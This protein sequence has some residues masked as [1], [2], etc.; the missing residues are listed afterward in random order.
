MSN[1]PVIRLTVGVEHEASLG[2]FKDGIKAIIAEI[3]KDPPK[4]K[5]GLEINQDKLNALR[6][7]ISAI[8][9]TLGASGIN[10]GSVNAS[11]LNGVADKISEIS[12]KSN[13]AVSGIMNIASSANN[14]RQ[15]MM[16]MTAGLDT[17]S[18]NIQ[19]LK[20]ALSS[21]N[22]LDETGVAKIAE[23]LSQAEVNIK[24]ISSSW[25]ETVSQVENGVERQQQL[26][27]LK[28]E[29]ANA[30][31]KSLSYLM[32]YNTETGEIETTIGRITQNFTNTSAS[33]KQI[34]DV[35]V[36]A[37]DLMSKNANAAGLGS[38]QNLREQALEIQ[39]VFISANLNGTSILDEYTKKGV[40]TTSVVDNIRT[41]MS[42]LNREM[43]QV[44][45]SG[46]VTENQLNDVLI[47]ANALIKNNRNA[48]SLDI[49]KALAN[50][51]GTLKNAFDIASRT[52]MTVFDVLNQGDGAGA[53]FSRMTSSV[54]ILNR[55]LQFTG[56]TGNVTSE[57][58]AK[59]VMNVR[60][61]LN[62]N[63]NASGLE[64]YKK[65]EEL[66]SPIS[67]LFSITSNNAQSAMDAIDKFGMN[68][69]TIMQDV[70]KAIVQLNLDIQATGTSGSDLAGKLAGE[71][72]NV[73]TAINNNPDASG[74]AS[75]KNA[76]LVVSQFSDIL[77]SANKNG[78]AVA[79][80]LS[81]YGY[82]PVN[83]INTLKESVRLLNDEIK[84]TGTSGNSGVKN[85]ID[86]VANA[87]KLLNSNNN[88]S[89]LNSY[90]EVE[91][92]IRIISDALK[93][94]ETNGTTFNQALASK[95]ISTASAMK[96]LGDA[97][98]QL[99]LDIENTGLSGS[100]IAEKLRGEIANAQ[101]VIDKNPDAK[102]LSSY[103]NVTGYIKQL[104][105]AL[106]QAEK[107]GV[108]A[109]DAL[110]R[111]GYT[112]AT[113]VQVLKDSVK[114]LNAEINLTGTSGSSGIQKTIDEVTRATKVL[115]DNTNA[116]G[117]DSYARVREQVDF[118]NS[119]INEARENGITLEGVLSK[120][121]TTPAQAMKN[122]RESVSQLNLEL[123]QTGTKGSTGI[124][125]INKLITQINNA[126]RNG[127][128]KGFEGTDDY[129]RLVRFRDMLKS[130]SDTMSSG[131]GI[132]ANVAAQANNIQNFAQFFRQAADALTSFNASLSGSE[133]T[134][135]IAKNSGEYYNKLQQIN[136]IIEEID[137]NTTRWN[138]A[139]KGRSANS[140]RLYTS[141]REEL[142]NLSRD[143]EN[144]KITS[145][146]FAVRIGEINSRMSE[147]A[148]TIRMAGENTQT[149]SSVLSKVSGRLGMWFSATTIIMRIVS[150]V[151]KMITETVELESAMTQLRIVTDATNSKMEQFADTSYRIAS[152]LGKNVKEILGSIE[153]FSRLGYSLEDA[154]VLTEYATILSNVAAV[155]ADDATS[156]LTSIIKGYNFDVQNAQHVADVLIEVGQKYA[157][158]AGEL[159]EAFK[160]SGAALSATNTSFEKSAALI[161]A[162]NASV[163]DSSTVGT[164]LKTISARIRGS[165]SDL[166]ELGESTDDLAQGFSKYADEIKSLTGFDIMVNK[167]SN[168]FKDLYDIMEGIAGT[169]DNLSDTQQ[170]RVAEILGGTRQLQV[171]SSI[172]T[173]WGDAADAYKS[174]ISSAGVATRVNDRYMATTA[175]HVEQL[176]VAFSE[177][178]VATFDTDFLKGIVDTGTS[179]LKIIKF[180]VEN[181]KPIPTLLM[182]IAAVKSFKSTDNIFNIVG[183]DA[184]TRQFSIF[185]QE[186]GKF[187]KSLSDNG[188]KGTFE[189]LFKKN[190]S[191]IEALAKY[192][193]LVK[194]GV[195]STDALTQA[196]KG[197]DAASKKVIENY[198][199]GVIPTFQ[200][201]QKQLQGV[202]LG[203]KAAAVA[204]NIL[205]AALVSIG[206][207]LIMTAINTVIQ[208]VKNIVTS[209]DDS[210]EDLKNYADTIK[211]IDNN[212]SSMNSEL[213][214]NL[215][216]LYELEKIE[217]PT[218]Y[219]Q[220]QIDMLKEA[221]KELRDRIRLLKYEL[222]LEVDA[223]D[224]QANQTWSGFKSPQKLNFP[225]W[226][227]WLPD[228]SKAS[229]Q[230]S[231]IGQIIAGVQGIS[232]FAQGQTFFQMAY[233]IDK[234]KSSID[235]LYSYKNVGG[236]FDQPDV[237][238]KNVKRLEDKISESQT[239]I[240]EY[241][242][243][244]ENIILQ[245]NPDIP[246]NADI[247]AEIESYISLI[248]NLYGQYNDTGYGTFTSVY[249]SPEFANVR[250]RLEELAA[251]GE[252]TEETFGSVEGIDAFVEA[253]R[254][255]NPELA[256]TLKIIE[257]VIGIVNNKDGVSP[258][259]QNVTASEIKKKIDEC[260]EYSE[261]YKKAAKGTALSAKE[262]YEILEK[263]PSLSEYVTE[264]DEGF[265]I[266][267]SGLAEIVERDVS[268][269]KAALEYSNAE[270]QKVIDEYEALKAESE[271]L[272]GE[273][274]GSGSGSGSDTASYYEA[275]GKQALQARIDYLDN[276]IAGK[277]SAYNEA[278]EAIS[279]NNAEINALDSSMDSHAIRMD[280]IKSRYDEVKKEVEDYNENITQIDSAIKKMNK[281]EALTYK[282]MTALVE[283]YPEIANSIEKRTDGYYIEIDALEDMRFESKKARDAFIQSEIDKRK[284]AIET[285]ETVV[286]ANAVINS[287][288][289][290]F[291]KKDVLNEQWELIRKLK[292]EI[293]FLE[294]AMGEVFSDDDTKDIDNALQ[295]EVDYYNSIVKAIEA[296]SDKKIKAIDDEIEALEKQKEALED[297]NDERE[298][299]LDLI[300]KRN[301]LEKAKKKTVFVFDKEKGFVERTDEKAI[302]EAQKEY[303]D[304]LREI[305]TGE[306][307]AQI[308][309]LNSE[310]DEIE[311]YKSS[312]TDISG[313]IENSI[314]IAQALKALG[315][316]SGSDLLTLTSSERDA[317]I[318]NLA[319]ATVRK[320]AN[321]NSDN[322]YY[323]PVSLNDVLTQFGASPEKIATITPTQGLTFEYADQ[324]LSKLTEGK[325]ETRTHVINN[326]S[327]V[328][329][330]NVF[331]FPNMG[332]LTKEEIIKSV[333][334]AMLDVFRQLNNNLR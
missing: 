101:Y 315:K 90:K 64:S 67:K 218:L 301:N 142:L 170:A 178:S 171:I 283:I 215:K 246:E 119:A 61:V 152:Q 34:T 86:A 212:I 330:S 305:K 8:Q 229:L 184:V 177:L 162:A 161:A 37:N 163:Q 198:S 195:S 254:K 5:V 112:P 121:G 225:D 78:V 114:S 106:N 38:F 81:N 33:I 259:N 100:N 180:L 82:T 155:S 29:G 91:Q 116:S 36:Q 85:A 243:Y 252:L 307:D 265:V 92:Q 295:N 241:R 17:G 255:A 125:E 20:A 298:R 216:L 271:K 312:F 131:N 313:D 260:D 272:K 231:A 10:I 80:V 266:S 199:T 46:T 323:I 6:E 7:S 219:E 140:Y 319:G 110:S 308:K 132:S 264:T 60:N 57:S 104:S 205:N 314:A 317:L 74:L 290:W 181:L 98:S 172:L 147:A 53:I 261:A 228:F 281:G 55:E 238:E 190:N 188:I 97:V 103:G 233:E 250:L 26:L 256:D 186:F 59:L 304:A 148:G 144:G 167:S 63:Q 326:N 169:W 105:D 316:V 327:G 62:N 135:P 206:V 288:Q 58:L 277:T 235:E 223:A 45:I 175:A 21:I 35:L 65:L 25:T 187:K 51:V 127:I 209:F 88:A 270:Y 221:N 24:R 154:S 84:A 297:D 183:F 253:L 211:D 248:D 133:G 322:S 213:D 325:Y 165:K 333:N 296:V 11:G 234:Y 306:I 318:K 137:K 77:E 117:L 176:K 302:R 72:R 287:A 245:L 224:K 150:A 207:G 136:K 168:T 208:G 115:N 189:S 310:K 244:L 149:L 192:E 69:Q 309:K 191:G 210:I 48:A 320:E 294:V 28:I 76:M 240:L 15:A 222:N 108:N 95:G 267:Y 42:E 2:A 182:S 96:S 4:I 113:A 214:N 68:T 73:Q 93:E 197:L 276:E 120:T 146:Q 227:D 179:A 269:E 173:N 331:Q 49:Y 109:A 39:K 247:I 332:E 236:R 22:G 226:L 52:G 145:E 16:T 278:T 143:L 251:A 289:D 200:Q 164:A 303:D 202:S 13:A 217:S 239:K 293:A 300:E 66:L 111:L 18:E 151:R 89:E 220:D 160:R 75:Y 83:A 141:Q 279:K 280:G 204:T 30:D 130:I 43:Q 299:E 273:I 99:K 268:K 70:Q 126:L 56:Q 9:T 174:A 249:E 1:Q 284:A 19:G 275:Q 31:G 232:R 282:E 285:A 122:L 129:N 23:Q 242:T 87:T 12:E 158:S 334:D 128:G 274:S 71:L 166:D 292:E 44:G 258:E 324:M 291:D 328:T 262:L 329:V 203:A 134:L 139:E 185:N 27:N 118:L 257:A 321:D 3:D 157:V 194:S 123:E 102:G 311:K 94:A 41:A 47:K 153:T 193:S 54:Q 40:D 196:T 124:S 79:E 237:Y 32:S 138:K 159:M 230:T 107:N 263:F 201:A 14:A 50:D 156:G 286:K